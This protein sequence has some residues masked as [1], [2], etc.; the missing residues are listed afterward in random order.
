MKIAL[1]LRDA[2]NSAGM[3]FT[4]MLVLNIVLDLGIVAALA[5]VMSRPVKL[6]EH[7]V[8][9]AARA[10]RR[11]PVAGEPAQVRGERVRSALRPLL[12]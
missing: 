4:L 3:T 11:R 7:G 8:Q 1:A 2:R 6:R 9:P 5:F 10:A 12:D